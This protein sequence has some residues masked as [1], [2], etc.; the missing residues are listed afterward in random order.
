MN[1]LLKLSLISLIGVIPVTSCQT[2]DI[3]VSQGYESSIT[4]KYSVVGK[5]DFPALSSFSTKATISEIAPGATV[6]IIV[7]PDNLPETTNDNTTVGVGLTNSS[8]N[9]VIN[10]GSGF[11]PEI[12]S[13][14]ILEASKRI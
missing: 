1:K 10:P 11:A 8:G 12:G 7:P 4:S 6:S 3:L 5:V 13:Y 2:S 14:Y 9:F